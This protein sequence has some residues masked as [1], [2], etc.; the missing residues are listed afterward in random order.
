LRRG[1]F[2]VYAAQDD[3][4]VAGGA[5]KPLPA[6]AVHVDHP[7]M[8]KRIPYALIAAALLVILLY[9]RALPVDAPAFLRTDTSIGFVY[10][11]CLGVEI[12]GVLLTRKG[13]PRA[14]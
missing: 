5:V 10:G 9:P 8:R 1:S 3:K 12:W 4:T 13:R 2:A 6:M 11:I 14:S 7:T